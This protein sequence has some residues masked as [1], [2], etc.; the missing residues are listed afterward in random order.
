MIIK[1]YELNKIN[2]KIKIFLLYGNN[3][4]FKD[5]IIK[6]FFENKFK[7]KIYRYDESE[8]LHNKEN[9]YNIIFTK[10]LFE[11]E[12][13]IIIS[14]VSDKIKDIIN[15]VIEKEIDD[16][17]IILNSNNL[18]KKSKL[19]SLFEKNKRT[20]CIPF[21]EDNS[22]TLSSIASSFFKEKKIPISQ[23][24]INLLIERC[25]G[26]RLNLKN[27]LNKIESFIKDKN[28]IDI[29]D[30]LKLTNLAENYNVAELIDN[31]L[32]KNPKKITTILNENNFSIEDCILIMR[33]LLAKTKRLHKLKKESQISKNI[34]NTISSFRPIIFWKDKNIVKQQ[35][36]KWPLYKIENLI[37]EINEIELLVK[38]NSH[39][40][41]NIVSDFI[42]NQSN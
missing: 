37:Y 36:E 20:V 10:S 1:T 35:I 40:S 7:K 16:T 30:I 33:T 27:E 22:Q 19:R 24:T 31:C 15:E 26:D 17:T 42:I 6:N 21:Y 3:N 39:N 8:I 34:D 12:K 13:L 29:E 25:R 28:K 41:L 5:E 9:F 4:G 32:A 18:D 11:D 38:K 23:E 2:N 14:R